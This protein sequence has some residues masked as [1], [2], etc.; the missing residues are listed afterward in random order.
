MEAA[1]GEPTVKLGRFAFTVVDTDGGAAKKPSEMKFGQGNVATVTSVD[2][3]SHADLKLRFVDAAPR[4]PQSSLV[5]MPSL[6]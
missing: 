1:T 3:K 6:W 2:L 5:A 4:S